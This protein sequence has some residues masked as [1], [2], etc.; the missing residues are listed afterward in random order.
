MYLLCIADRKEIA[1]PTPEIFKILILYQFQGI[2]KQ[3]FIL[4]RTTTTA[5]STFTY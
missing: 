3:A 4:V 5:E 1:L 2:R